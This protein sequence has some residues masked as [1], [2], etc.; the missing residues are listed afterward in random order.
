MGGFGSGTW[1]RGYKRPTLDDVYRVDIRWLWRHNLLWTWE[2]V[3]PTMELEWTPCYYGGDRPW[4]RCPACDRRV[5]I[6]YG[7]DT[8][9]WC[10]HC[11][12]LPYASQQATREERL[13]RKARKVRERLGA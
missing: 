10:R 3:Q 7:A 13:Q 9:W 6:L 12:Q 8:G 4:F 1:S 11:M 2:S 5:A